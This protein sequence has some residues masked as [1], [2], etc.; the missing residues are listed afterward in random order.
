M[1]T[2]STIRNDLKDIRYYFSRKEVFDKALDSVGKSSFTEKIDKYNEV[3]K[4]APP[5]L[6]DLYVSLYLNNNTQESLADKL[7]Y[8][9]EH[10]SR[11]N[12]GLIKFI[13]KELK[14]KEEEQKWIF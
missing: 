1:V 14:S 4:N 9:L 7:G 12:S 8:T 2:V 6:Y 3:I 10:I 11:L 13:Q 5:R